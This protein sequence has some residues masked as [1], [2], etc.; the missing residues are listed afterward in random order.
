MSRPLKP[1]VGPG[2]GRGWCLPFIVLTCS[3]AYSWA[4]HRPHQSPMPAQVNILVAEAAQR[5][6]TAGN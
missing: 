3:R 4:H 2:A 6:H 1:E 5:T